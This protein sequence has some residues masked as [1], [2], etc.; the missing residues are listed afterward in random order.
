MASH[1]LGIRD[2]D[3]IDEAAIGASLLIVSL[4]LE[5]CPH[6]ISLHPVPQA[7]AGGGVPEARLNSLLVSPS[8]PPSVMLA[9]TSPDS[10]SPLSGLP[11]P[12]GS[13]ISSSTVVSLL[14]PLA[15]SAPVKTGYHIS[16]DS[17]LESDS[18]F[19]SNNPNTDVNINSSSGTYLDNGTNSLTLNSS[20]SSNSLNKQS[21]TSEVRPTIP[22][23]CLSYNGLFDCP[24]FCTSRLR[25][26]YLDRLPGCKRR[27]YSGARLPGSATT[28]AA[29]QIGLH[30][31]QLTLTTLASAHLP[32][33]AVGS[34]F[35]SNGN[36]VRTRAAAAAAQRL[37]QREQQQLQQQQQQLYPQKHPIES[38]RSPLGEMDGHSC[39]LTNEYPQ[40]HEAIGQKLSKI[41]L[42]NHA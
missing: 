35:G 20:N 28:A 3:R 42:L 25:S 19:C 22:G 9:F 40:V 37:I 41:L 2:R 11:L 13:N 36:A 1:R 24:S 38:R 17:S 15:S 21:F 33:G 39:L 26:K 23:T 6:F 10:D 5:A 29:V 8:L 31:G 30:A 34:S 32:A 16:A 14:S 4:L 27:L 12:T 7:P 18:N